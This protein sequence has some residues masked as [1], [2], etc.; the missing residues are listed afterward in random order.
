MTRTTIQLVVFDMAGTTVDEDNVV[1]KTLRDAINDQGFNCSLEHVLMVGGGQE[2]KQAIRDLL[3]G[4]GVEKAD[5][6]SMANTAYRRFITNLEQAYLNLQVMPC[7][8]SE[9]VFS[10]LREQGIKVALNTG[11]Q[12]KTATSLLQKLGW[13]VGEQID[14]M[15]TASDVTNS[16]PAPDMILLAMEKLGIDQPEYVVKIGDTAIDVEEG[17]QAGC[18]LCFG[19]LGGAQNREQIARANPDGILEHLSELTEWVGAD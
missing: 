14:L 15:V 18:G 3:A 5:L 17:Q 12:R 4:E 7:P 9:T 16:R 8:G 10:Q 1:Y 19:V 13:Q 11:Y 2:K 6:E